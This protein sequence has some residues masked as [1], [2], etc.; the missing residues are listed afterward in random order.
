LHI[1]HYALPTDLQGKDYV[2]RLQK[3]GYRATGYRL[4]HSLMATV[5][6]A[7]LL[8]ILL[9][10]SAKL[11]RAPEGRRNLAGGEA[12][13]NHRNKAK[14]IVRVPAG[15]PELLWLSNLTLSCAP[16]A[17]P[18]AALRFATG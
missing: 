17:L 3:R 9:A 6:G 7:R 15:T 5:F 2:C 13:R 12:K 10:N 18:V 14:K 8:G 11:F 4:R 1:A 16:S